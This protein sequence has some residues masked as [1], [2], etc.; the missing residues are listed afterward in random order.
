MQPYQAASDA[1]KRQKDEPG[2]LLKKAAVAGAGLA[3]AGPLAA[4]ILPLLSEF[5]PAGLAA[6]GLSKVDPR[7][8][9]F[10]QGAT[11]NGYPIGEAIGYLKDKFS[12]AS[13]KQEPAKENRNILEQYS[14][15]L[16]QL[17]LGLVQN[18]QSPIAAA[19]AAAKSGKYSK[20]IAQIQ[21]DHKTG[22]G[23]IVQSIF[24]GG[25]MA[26]QQQSKAAVYPQQSQQQQQQAQGGAN[27]DQALLAALEKILTM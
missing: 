3:A 11:D 13:E 16:Y 2:E 5:I 25:Q 22:L 26:Q 19:T 7:L 1:I 10:I 8:G 9:K 4:R 20:E 17:I 24:G 6:K 14:P 12:G 15:E 27:S 23:A 21:K 18:G